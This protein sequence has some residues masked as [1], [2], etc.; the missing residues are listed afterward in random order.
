MRRPRLFEFHEQPWVPAIVRDSVVESLY[1][2]VRQR[3]MLAGLI[4]PLVTFLERTGTTRV[5]DLCS[6]AGG[7]ALILAEELARRG[8]E[9]P[10]IA[11]SDFYPKVDVWEAAR[12][13]LQ[14]D[15]D[16]VTESVPAEDVPAD[17]AQGCPR[18][19]SNAFHHF[20]PDTARAI[21]ADAMAN[22]PGIFISESF[23]PGWRGF[24]SMLWPKP[25]VPPALPWLTRTDK[26][27]KFAL[28]LLVPVIPAALIFD[29]AVSTLRMYREDE[30]HELVA[31]L[32]D[33]FEWVYGTC[34]QGGLDCATFFYG[35]RR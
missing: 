23:P 28:T 27:K 8:H 17:V 6:G 30:F 13:S 1:H 26:A 5:L 10:R 12:E 15:F 21:L 7:V 33:A 11:L 4:G 34:P 19:I 9:A 18:M 31:P 35:V 22:S 29:G 20:P 3:G 2:L 24:L 16:Y 25:W 14:L 32:G